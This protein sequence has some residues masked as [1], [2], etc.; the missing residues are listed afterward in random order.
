MTLFYVETLLCN[1]HGKSHCFE[2]KGSLSML[3]LRLS[4]MTNDNRFAGKKSTLFVYH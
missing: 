2:Y 3:T 1:S 4:F